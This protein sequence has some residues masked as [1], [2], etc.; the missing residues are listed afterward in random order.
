MWQRSRRYGNVQET[1]PKCR[2][3]AAGY[4]TWAWP[5]EAVVPPSTGTTAP[6]T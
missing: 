4:T 1:P 2:V 3:P 5:V 6:V